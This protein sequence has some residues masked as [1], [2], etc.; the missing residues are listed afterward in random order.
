[1]SNTQKIHGVNLANNSVLENLCVEQLISDP[2]PLTKSG[3]IWYNTTTNQLKISIYDG[4]SNIVVKVL[5]SSLLDNFY[6]GIVLLSKIKPSVDSTT[7]VMITK[8][9]GSTPVATFDTTNK[10][11]TVSGS[12]SGSNINWRPL[13]AGTDFNITAASTSTITMITNQTPDI[14]IGDQIK[15]KLSGGVY[16]FGRCTAITSNLLTIGGAPL[17]T[18]AS[19]LTE[20]YFSKTQYFISPLSTIVFSGYFASATNTTMLETKL[21]M[22]GGYIWEHPKVYLVGVRIIASSYDIG[23][24]VTTQPAFNITRNG[25]SMLSTGL[26]IANGTQ[27]ISGIQFNTAQYLISYND[28][29]ECTVSA[30]SGGTPL[31]N[32]TNLKVQLYYVK[33]W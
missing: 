15:F 11:L 14:N 30:A 20:L 31:N 12:V 22:K 23:V 1:M 6:N 9:D 3:R 28:V 32:S 21:S 18:T 19:A 29:I 27:V 26:T 16:Y 10:N 5:N 13:I 25:S 7:A 33:D 8:A 4:V 2:S 17:T 24:G